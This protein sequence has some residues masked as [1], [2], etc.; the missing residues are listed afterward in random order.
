MS[1]ATHD[2]GLTKVP[3]LK[4]P[5]GY[6]QWKR[7]VLAV[8]CREDPLEECF[9]ENPNG[10]SVKWRTANAKAKSTIILC[11]GAPALS[12]IHI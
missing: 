4:S 12:L 2:A 5:S 8:I 3:L 7:S 1:H 10:N 11:L 6:I 9:E